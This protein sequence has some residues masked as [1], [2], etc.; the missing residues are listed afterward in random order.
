MPD[1]FYSVSE[2]PK[3]LILSVLYNLFSAALN[4]SMKSIFRIKTS[5]QR[6]ILWKHML[7]VYQ[8]FTVP[9][10]KP[11]CLQTTCASRS[12]QRSWQT[13]PQWVP[14]RETSTRP[15][16]FPSPPSSRTKL[17]VTRQDFLV[18]CQSQQPGHFRNPCFHQITPIVFWSNTAQRPN[19]AMFEVS[20]NQ[21]L[22][23][24]RHVTK[25]CQITSCAKYLTVKVFFNVIM[26]LFVQVYIELKV[27]LKAKQG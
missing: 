17:A 8:I 1:N 16:V 13:V 4:T 12:D 24:V 21:A 18:H 11:S 2:I 7:I 20:E 19:C 25:F 23:K 26:S 15:F 27:V 3:Y 14:F 22:T 9:H 6:S 10:L 5:E